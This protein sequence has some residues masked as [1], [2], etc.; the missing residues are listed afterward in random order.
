MFQLLVVLF[1][2]E[3]QQFK[4]LEER[5]SEKYFCR[6]FCGFVI[7]KDKNNSKYLDAA[8]VVV[9]SRLFLG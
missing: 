7:F 2:K 5:F 6:S 3:W 8:F 4:F 1:I 9:V